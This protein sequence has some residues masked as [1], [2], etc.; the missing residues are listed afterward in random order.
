MTAPRLVI[1]NHPHPSTARPA[2][3]SLRLIDRS[4]T[5]ATTCGSPNRLVNASSANR[6]HPR[7]AGWHSWCVVRVQY[8]R[9]AVPMCAEW[10]RAN[11]SGY[12]AVDAA[13][14]DAVAVAAVEKFKEMLESGECWELERPGSC[15]FCSSS[16][17]L[18]CGG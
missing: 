12:V 18:S 7:R 9:D 5:T 13:A 16:S 17:S 11:I 8:F 2:P 15:S 14:V 3:S 4:T 1:R 10:I 6:T